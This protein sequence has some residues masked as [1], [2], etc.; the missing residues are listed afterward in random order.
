M[1]V[2]DVRDAVSKKV[3]GALTTRA[4]KSSGQVHQKKILKMLPRHDRYD[5][6]LH[7]CIFTPSLP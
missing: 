1:V 3:A 6:P 5:N 2:F 4:V 7:L